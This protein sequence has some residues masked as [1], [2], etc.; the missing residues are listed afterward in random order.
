[1]DDA[2][3]AALNIYPVKGCAGIALTEATM[4][5]T[6]L[7]ASGAGDR[8]WMIVDRHG[9]LVTQREFPRLALVDVATSNDMLWLIDRRGESGAVPLAIPMARER[10]AAIPVRVWNSHVRGHDEGDIAAA[11]LT[12]YLG[13]E[14]RLVR[15]DREV[16][17]N[18]NPEFAG[19]SGAHTMYADGYP[20]LII[21]QASLDDLNSRLSLGGSASLPMNR[22]R[23]NVVL[24]GLDAFAEDHIDTIEAGDVTLRLVKPCVRCQVTTTDQES[25]AAV[26]VEPLQTLGEFR[27][28]EFMGG[29]TFGMNAIVVA[30]AGRPLTRGMSTRIEYRF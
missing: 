12:R 27:M 20:L 8:E 2:R 26:G 23:P 9:N 21:S 5:T 24:E 1:M 18:C 6:G 10:S 7:V 16:P 22:F 11:W 29:V 25:T 17:R 14:V 19:D 3:I 15:F 30:G 28:D 4:A 13:A